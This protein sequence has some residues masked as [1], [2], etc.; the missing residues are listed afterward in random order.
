MSQAWA[1]KWA[2]QFFAA[3]YFRCVCV[4]DYRYKQAMQEAV[5]SNATAFIVRRE[6]QN[7]AGKPGKPGVLSLLLASLRP[8]VSLLLSR[9]AAAGSSCTHCD[10][11]RPNMNQCHIIYVL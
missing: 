5:P 6:A 2:V 1:D 7:N 9:S 3:T 10:S 11:G 4:V 8:P